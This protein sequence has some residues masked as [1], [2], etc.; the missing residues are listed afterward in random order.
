MKHNDLGMTRR[1]IL[2][3][4][5]LYTFIHYYIIPLVTAAVSDVKFANN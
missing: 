1:G 5:D 4:L 3:R 2:C